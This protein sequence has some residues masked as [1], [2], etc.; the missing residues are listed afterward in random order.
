[1]KQERFVLSQILPQNPILQESLEY[2]N[3]YLTKLREY[4]LLLGREK[5][6]FETAELKL[7]Q[8]LMMQSHSGAS[9]N[10]FFHYRYFLLMDAIFCLGCKLTESEAKILMQQYRKD[11][12]LNREGSRTANTLLKAFTRSP[13]RLEG[14][15]K[16]PELQ[17]ERKYLQL[18]SWNSQFQNKKPYR[19]LVTAT[20][21]AGKSTFINSLVG[22][23]ICKSQ[24]MA[25]TSKIHTVINKAFEDGLAYEYDHD[26]VLTASEEELMNDNE[27]NTSDRITVAVRF[28]GALQNARIVISDSP[29]VNF[30]GATEHREITQEMIRTKNYD[31]LIY[32][33]NATQLATT[34]EE[35][36]LAFIRQTVGD[37]PVLFVLNKVD[38]LNPEKEN[39]AEI[40]QKMKNYLELHGFHNPLICPVSSQAGWM[41]K[42][43]LQGELSGTE[44][45]KLWAYMGRFQKMN[46][47][48]YYATEFPRAGVDHNME[49]EQLRRTSGLAYVE[50]IIML[51][52][53]GRN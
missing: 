15:M 43:E 37:A 4:I 47:P 1:M 32:V 27:E 9:Q 16:H 3:L 12:T 31:L 11:F 33:M 28:N 19:I 2:K 35:E 22:K 51:K 53:A 10:K 17:Q 45:W 30:S 14:L 7:Y 6:K 46:L 13:A 38:E 29:G 25:C 41:A 52:A 34:D 24:N 42:R 36:H 18:L 48:E 40:F 49:R 23:E 20:M 50:K 44:Q 26:L 5:E 39:V 8:K 21:S